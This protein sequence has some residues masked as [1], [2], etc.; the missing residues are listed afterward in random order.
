MTRLN[1][2]NFSVEAL[3]RVNQF[4]EKSFDK[5]SIF[6]DSSFSKLMWMV[7]VS[8]ALAA[9]VAPYIVWFF[10]KNEINKIKRD[11]DKKL[12]EH[13]N[14][15]QDSFEEERNIIKQIEKDLKKEIRASEAYSFLY[16]SAGSTVSKVSW[17]LLENAVDSAIKSERDD[18][19]S[20]CLTRAEAM[21]LK[22][23]DCGEYIA[24]TI[25]QLKNHKKDDFHFQARVQK[26]EEKFNKIKEEN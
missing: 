15:F 18:L 8:G 14:R 25:Q 7:G 5:L 4:Y 22:T 3:D 1:P 12:N 21:E 6:Y 16:Q 2:Q 26:I 13:L 20:S 11:Y 17:I 24:R 9:F 19:L 10:Q 23:S